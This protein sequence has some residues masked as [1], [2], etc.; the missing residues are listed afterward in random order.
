MSTS[1]VRSAIRYTEQRGNRLAGAVSFYG[2]VS[3][4][5][6]LT[7]IGSITLQLIGSEG[8]QTVQEITDE[9]L[10]GLEIDV[11]ALAGNAG[12]IGLVGAIV[13]LWT[14]LA[15]VDSAR[16][17]VR[18]MWRLD[19]A[20]GKYVTRKLID[21]VVLVGLGA[22]LLVSWA[23]TVMV[24]AAADQVLGWLGI[25]DGGSWWISRTTALVVG[26]VSSAVLF[27]YLLAG[28]PRIPVP[29]R[30]LLPAA[31]LGGLVFE[32]LKQLVTQYAVLAVPD[33][34]YAAFAVPLA[35]LAWIYLV[36]RLLMF[37]A[38]STAEWVAEHSTQPIPVTRDQ[39]A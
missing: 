34:T 35:L 7:L 23:A 24:D 36:A 31:A 21:L 9:Y 18:S 1:A 38:A 29:I 25:D 37:L 15:W 11:A 16:A 33:N 6:L 17:A 3:L 28:L 4:F 12:T 39:A 32:L 8:L 13:L 14:G 30:V 10:P 5:A 2:F 27:G 22:V 19:D 26:L 20:P